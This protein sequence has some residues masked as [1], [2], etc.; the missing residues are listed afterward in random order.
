MIVVLN[1]LICT[2]WLQPWTL[3]H[4]AHQASSGYRSTPTLQS[5][6]LCRA[7]RRIKLQQLPICIIA[8]INF[9]LQLLD[10][11]SFCHRRNTCYP[12]RT[13]LWL[14]VLFSWSIRILIA[15][16]LS[17]AIGRQIQHRFVWAP[18]IGTFLA[19]YRWGQ[20]LAK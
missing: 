1:L 3:G 9:V 10:R 18:L 15:T 16:D 11:Q 2:C 20:T 19:S 5:V 4:S 12:S 13:A 7:G 6:D 14:I 17:T 8:R